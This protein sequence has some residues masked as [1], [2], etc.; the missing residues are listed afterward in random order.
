M[1]NRNILILTVLLLIITSCSKE[2]VNLIDKK[3]N[4]VFA[5]G[6]NFEKLKD[7]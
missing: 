2:E 6:L 4:P 1:K 5:N 7:L 3:A